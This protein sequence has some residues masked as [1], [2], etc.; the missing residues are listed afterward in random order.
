MST[1]PENTDLTS[2]ACEV[3]AEPVAPAVAPSTLLTLD[4]LRA[5]SGQK[6]LIIPASVEIKDISTADIVQVEVV[7]SPN[8]KPAW[9]DRSK[10]IDPVDRALYFVHTSIVNDAKLWDKFVRMVKRAFAPEP[11][12]PRRPDRQEIVVSGRHTDEQADD[13]LQAVKIF[14]NLPLDTYPNRI[15]DILIQHNGEAS[16]VRFDTDEKPSLVPYTA[17]S[18]WKYLTRCARF[19]RLVRSGGKTLKEP[20]EHPVPHIAQNVLDTL[21]RNPKGYAQKT[22]GFVEVPVLRPDGTILHTHGYDSETGIIYQPDPKLDIPDIP[23]FPSPAAITAARELVLEVIHD[24]PFADSASRAN[25]VALMFS[26]IVRSA[27]DGVVPIALINASDA[28]SGKSYLANV[29]S[30]IATGQEAEI[31]S[32]P[33]DESEMERVITTLLLDNNRKVI[34]FDNLNRQLSSG[35][36]CAA[37]TSVV[38]SDRVIRTSTLCKI[39]NLATWIF[40]GNAISLGGDMPRRCYLINLNAGPHPEQRDASTFLHHP[41][42]PWVKENRGRIIAA[43]LTMARA[44]YV[45]KCPAP[46]DRAH[47]GGFET[48]VETVQGILAYAGIPGCLGNLRTVYGVLD[49]E[50][51]EWESFLLNIREW[52]KG[53]PFSTADLV[54]ALPTRE[55]LR[56]SLPTSIT[57]TGK[58]MSLVVG[59]AFR[60]RKGRHHGQ[61][62]VRIVQGPPDRHSKVATWLVEVG[63]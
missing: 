44:W 21:R 37:I 18:M 13:A 49:E 62:A 27:I 61:S 11:P 9:T 60:T 46:S 14:N 5:I 53:S 42:F 33:S 41:L 4:A 16:F 3:L 25:A 35:A 1:N 39:P 28:G 17:S 29:V 58:E 52:S 56:N 63:A 15:P 20:V 6:Q 45:A 12:P 23:V 30:I 50:G 57:A 54:A 8:G 48:W 51:L 26:P 19:F 55:A 22:N 36:L 47:L 32:I 59:T 24:F 38:W 10:P 43:L 34:C 7:I 2:E 40:T 31:K